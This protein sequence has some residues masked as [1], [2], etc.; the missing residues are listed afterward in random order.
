MSKNSLLKEKSFWSGYYN[1]TMI[2]NEFIVSSPQFIDFLTGGLFFDLLGDVKGKRVLSIGG[3]VDLTAIYL[4][5]Q[6]AC[7]LS[8]DISDSACERTKDLIRVSGLEQYARVLKLNCEDMEFNSEFDIIISCKAL[9]HM[10]IN[11]VA[12]RIHSALKTGGSFLAIEPVC[13]LSFIKYIHRR[14][15]FHPKYPVTE[16]EIELAITELNMIKDAFSTVDLYYFDFLTRPMFA[17]FLERMRLKPILSVIKKIDLWIVKSIPF[18]RRFS[19]Q[20]MIS[21]VK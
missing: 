2:D 21:G 1:S 8:M 9:H 11:K 6:G 14:F 7:V 3:G 10:E 4:A 5:K 16:S 20:I 15:P 12:K 13:V 17:Y 19:S 18:F